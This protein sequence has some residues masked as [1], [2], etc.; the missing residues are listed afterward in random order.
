MIDGFLGDVSWGLRLYKFE[1]IA[2]VVFSILQNTLTIYRSN[3][4]AIKV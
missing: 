2:F 4:G 3:I 1:I